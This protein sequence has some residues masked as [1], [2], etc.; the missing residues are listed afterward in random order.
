MNYPL[1]ILCAPSYSTFTSIND[2]LIIE[3]DWWSM[4]RCSRVYVRYTGFL[5]NGQFDI[6]K[7]SELFQ[8][9]SC[10]NIFKPF[11]RGR[12]R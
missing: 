9:L 5:V 10:R 2:D 11:H 6:I 7:R 8:K 1:D 3:I 4:G 12:D